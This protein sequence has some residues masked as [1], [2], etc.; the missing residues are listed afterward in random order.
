MRVLTAATARHAP[1]AC[2]HWSALA[3]NASRES[4]A[5]GGYLHDRYASPFTR[6]FDQAVDD[7]FA[8]RIFAPA[9][10][11]SRVC[12]ADGRVSVGAT[13]IQRVLLGPVAIET[14]VRVVEVER[15]LERASFAYA[16]LLGHPERGI[17]SFAVIRDGA[18]ARFEAE[19][20]SRAGSWITVVGRPVSRALQRAIT[21]EAVVSFCRDAGR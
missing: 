3:T 9:R 8:Y 21:R 18:R 11:V 10:M 4:I 13:I 6:D 15:T 17:A 1:F 14:A 20:W 7:L 16:T 12:A 19:A 5:G 2:D